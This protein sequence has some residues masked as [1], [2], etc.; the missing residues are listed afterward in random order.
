MADRPA[1]LPDFGDPPVVEVVLS[2]Q[3]SELRNY[4]TTHAG[5]LW[6][7]KFRKVFPHFSEHPPIAPAFETFG[8][9]TAPE[10]SVQFTPVP[11]PP[12]PRLWFINED[13][14]QLIQF[15]GDR[16]THNWRKVESGNVY[17][18]YEAIKRNFFKELAKVEDFLKKENIGRI[19]ANQCEV[20]YVNH[21]VLRND[22]DI[23]TQPEKVLRFWS[24]VH[25]DSSDEGSRL[26]ELDDAR[27]ATRYVINNDEGSPIGRLLAMAEPATGENERPIIRFSL[28][29][30]GAPSKPTVSAVS[31]FFDIGREAIVRGFTAM[32]TPTMHKIWKRKK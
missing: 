4:R 6:Q 29:A 21:I 25:V 22:Q 18:R 16:F 17:P 28:T 14:T 12:V 7:R 5:L 3:F 26:P 8:P 13:R 24:G 10:V 31:E 11:G 30:R 27:F 23:R 1:D 15:Q 2:V 19:E 32:T 20:T 9:R